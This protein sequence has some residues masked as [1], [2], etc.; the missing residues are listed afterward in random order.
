MSIPLIHKSLN[1]GL[2]KVRELLIEL[3]SFDLGMGRTHRYHDISDDTRPIESERNY[4]RSWLLDVAEKIHQ[5]QEALQYFVK[6]SE[7][8]TLALSE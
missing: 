5:Y 2:Q 3:Q 4:D 1:K 6:T 8:V 7:K